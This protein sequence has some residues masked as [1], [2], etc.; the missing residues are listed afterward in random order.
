MI[1]IEILD[2]VYSENVNNQF[3]LNNATTVDDWTVLSSSEASSA[4][5]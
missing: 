1:S 3:N 5:G 4:P 2:Y